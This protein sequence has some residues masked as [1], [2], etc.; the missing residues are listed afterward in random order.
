MSNNMG[1]SVTVVVLNW[2]N[3]GETASC[4]NSLSQLSYLNYEVC[5]VDNGSDDNS[6]EQLAEEFDWCN[7][8]FSNENRGFAG[9]CNLGI[10]HALE[11]GSEYILLLN[12]DIVADS[13]FLSPL[14]DTAER[15][16]RVAAVGGVINDASGEIWFAGG[17]FLPHLCRG[18][19][20]QSVQKQEPYE[21]EF[22]TGA[23][24][25]LNSDFVRDVGGLNEDYF[26]GMEDLDLSLTARRRGWK[27][28]ID[29]KATV[30]HKVSSSAGKQSPF[31]YYHSTR[32]RMYLASSKLSPVNQL[33]FYTVFIVTRVIRFLQW[34]L[35]GRRDLVHA[36]TAGIV[37]YI[38]DS[39]F[40]QPSDLNY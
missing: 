38:G 30:V 22:I 27:L 28:L 25:L 33:V 29:P 5:V 21:T 15:R 26:F 12:N 17:K 3:Y 10:Q 19:H 24:M 8:V 34:I 9:G 11:N 4:L 6:G 23:M 32:N 18:T 40:K 20:I 1:P 36:S 35:Q 37:D 2:N 39:D 14:V 16:S 31:K 13:D 7:F